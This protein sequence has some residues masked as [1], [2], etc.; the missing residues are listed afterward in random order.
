MAFSAEW[1]QLYQRGAQNSI[2]PWSDLISFVMRYARPERQPY[3]VLELG[4]GAGANISFFI[5][6]GADYSGT[7]G[8]ATA[9][10]RVQSRF[11]DEANIC[12]K[13][14]DFTKEIPFEGPFD[15][16]VDRASL[17]HNGT[18]AIEECLLRVVGKMRSGAKF[19]GID[20]FSTAN[21]DFLSGRSTEDHFTRTAFPP[22]PFQ[23]VG[24]VHFFDEIH[25]RDLL[26]RAGLDIERLEHKQSDTLVPGDLGR[27]AWWNFAATKR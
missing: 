21:D 18:A 25:L 5:S 10:E 2:W 24:T 3:R 4:V 14:C 27:L 17:A 6:I 22:G 13:C 11:A 19:I 8:S 15:L 26:A 9:V 16:V 23:D 7:E 20:W 1:E 12:V